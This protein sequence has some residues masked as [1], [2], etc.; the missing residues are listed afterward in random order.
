MRFSRH[1]RTPCAGRG[2]TH[3]DVRDDLLAQ[4]PQIAPEYAQLRPQRGELA[5]EPREQ[6]RIDGGSH[7][8]MLVIATRAGMSSYPW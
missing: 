3:R 2:R 7:D 8:F 1:A 6:R 4:Q 5:G